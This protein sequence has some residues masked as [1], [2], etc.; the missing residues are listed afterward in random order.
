MSLVSPALAGRFFTIS[1]T[2]EAHIASTLCLIYH[3][4]IIIIALE[5]VT[6]MLSRV[7]ENIGFTSTIIANI[8]I[9]LAVK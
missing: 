3:L 1:T 6:Y 7:Y 2:W 5:E 9:V 4:H 8:F